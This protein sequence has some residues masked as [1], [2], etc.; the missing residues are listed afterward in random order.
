M[1]FCRLTATILAII[2]ILAAAARGEALPPDKEENTVFTFWP[3]IDY[4][5]NPTQKTSRLSLLGPLISFDRT[6]E[7]TTTALRP[8]L[9]TS[10]DNKTGNSASY[11]AYPLASSE[12]TPDVSRF[13]LLHL[14]QKDV[15]RKAEPADAERK[16][17]FFPFIINGASKK[18]GPYTSVFPLYGDI[19]ERFWRDEYHYVL[20]PLY[21]RTVKKGTT[22]YNLLWPFFSRT[23]GEK[24]TGFQFWPLYGH[25]EKDGVYS[26]TFALWPIFSKETR[27]LDTDNPSSRFNIFPLYSEFDSTYIRS[28][29]W[30]W[31]FFGHST[32]SRENEEEWDILWPFWLTVRGEKR[33]ITKFL[34]FY[35]DEESRD[36][37]R[38]WYL[39][40]LYRIDTM[41][42][43]V[44][45][46]ERQKLLYFLYSDRTESWAVDGKSRRRTAMWPLFVY[47]RD[48]DDN[49]SLTLPAPVEPILDKEGIEKSWAPLWRVYVQ[50]W[51]GRG[52][53]SL[54]LFWN[55]YWH[56][57]S[58]ESVAWELFPLCSY[59]G[60]KESTEIKLLKGLLAY[61][62]ESDRG[63]FSLFW[64]PL[65]FTWG[66]KSP[67]PI[68]GESK[69]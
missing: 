62:G 53:S 49:M 5:E 25:A 69:P 12:S 8:L 59:R 17:M 38:N 11:Y 56:E 68:P 46:Q 27:G 47:N 63:S 55:L 21:S 39:W 24:E 19:Y 16:F 67:Q 35:S 6:G 28:R 44:Y 37:T 14:L 36:A 65:D 18:Y 15:F 61:R 30:L 1:N 43:T 23:V 22:N 42:S 2:T 57:N 10:T 20:F 31:P 52:D 7:E 54:S 34:P 51:N 50:N 33:N 26:S 66:D 13:Q 40:P 29:T 41:Q 45:R 9:H 60:A 4:R 3:L 58:S 32:N 48:A 64:L